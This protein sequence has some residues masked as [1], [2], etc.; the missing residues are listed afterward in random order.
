MAN[1]AFDQVKPLLATPEPPGLGPGPRSGV[2]GMMQLDAKL[3]GLWAG[4][5]FHL[6]S[7]GL[8]KA[9]VYLWHDH[10]GPAHL[11][12]Q[13]VETADGSF[14][15]AIVH[16]REPDYSN[17]KYWFRRVGAHASF[18]EIARRVEV[19]LK[20]AG[21]DDLRLLRRGEWDPFA[22]VD[23]CERADEKRTEVLREIQR[24]EIEALLEYF[25]NK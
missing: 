15:H 11:L 5:I 4:T 18:P 14:V 21:A 7:L 17:A 9:L 24:I 6:E 2:Q 25:L 3:E 12:A 16:R 8:A 23:A 10:L 22:F 20:P 13:N 19:L 1:A